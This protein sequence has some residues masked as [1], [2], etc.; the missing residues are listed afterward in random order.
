LSSQACLCTSNDNHPQWQISPCPELLWEEETSLDQDAESQITWADVL[1]AWNDILDKEGPRDLYSNAGFF[2]GRLDCL[3][4]GGYASWATMERA[5]DFVMEWRLKWPQLHDPAF[6]PLDSILH[7]HRPDF[8]L[9]AP[10]PGPA[11]AS[12]S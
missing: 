8:C 1:E 9:E 7:S 5:I 2:L 4:S 10:E 12:A 6:E 3:V 11:V